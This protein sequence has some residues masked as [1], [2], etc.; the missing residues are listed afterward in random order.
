MLEIHKNYIVDEN[1]NPIAVQI[2]IAEFEKIEE[3]LEDY[4]LGKMMEDAEDAEILSKS[5]AL[6]YY[7][8]LKGNNVGC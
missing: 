7:Q 1:Q 4:F 6:K 3:I 2:P 5:E 8:R